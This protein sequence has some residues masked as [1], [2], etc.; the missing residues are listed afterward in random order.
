MDLTQIKEALRQTPD[1]EFNSGVNSAWNKFPAELVRDE[2][3]HR[4]KLLPDLST[5]TKKIKFNEII[6]RYHEAV[7]LA[8]FR[9][10]S[11]DFMQMDEF[12]GP[13]ARSSSKAYLDKRKAL[14]EEMMEHH[15]QLAEFRSKRPDPF[16][17]KV[18][19][20]DW[21]PDGTEVCPVCQGI[22]KGSDRR[23]CSKCS[24]KGFIRR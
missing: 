7:N 6:D 1:V 14:F 11:D 10:L 15:R 12:F 8:S 2:L 22:G 24:G 23:L 3:V 16:D 17:G 5:D 18:K 13:N 4:L 20:G 21:R 19:P 9:A